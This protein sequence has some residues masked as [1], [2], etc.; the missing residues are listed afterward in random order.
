MTGLEDTSPGVLSLLGRVLTLR[1]EP[2]AWVMREP[3]G[4]RLALAVVVLAGLSE[5]LGQSVV[6]FANR[7][8]PRRFVASLFLSAGLYTAG[9]VL[10]ALSVW[11]VGTYVF[12]AQQT[13][14]TVTKAVG[15][16]YAPYLFAFFI[17]TPFWG[18]GVSVALSLWSLLAVLVAVQVTLSLTLA[19]A[20][21]CSALGW[22]LLQLLR[23][24]VGRPVIWGVLW[25]RGRIAGVPLITGREALQ[26]LLHEHDETRG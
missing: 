6:L 14:R 23:R 12:D 9:F 13:L 2:F 18:D 8:K 21:L 25:L 17:L 4:L 10:W 1:E 16:A 19:Q 22:V 15:L 26:E 24:T 7:V 3:A 5:A 11:L 20:L